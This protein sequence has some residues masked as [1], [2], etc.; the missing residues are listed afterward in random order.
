MSAASPV[1]PGESLATA[2]MVTA[3]GAI[4]SRS[5]RRCGSSQEDCGVSE[6]A[7]GAIDQ[8]RDNGGPRP[9][10]GRNQIMVEMVALKGDVFVRTYKPL[11]S[12]V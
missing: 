11:T 7:A 5:T 6:R 1:T 2:D 3:P 4:E 9:P 12:S 10:S 8:Q